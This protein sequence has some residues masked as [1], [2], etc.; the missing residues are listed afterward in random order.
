[1]T[2]G[3]GVLVAGALSDGVSFARSGA[4][5]ATTSINALAARMRMS[6]RMVAYLQK[7]LDV[8]C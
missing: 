7:K 6:V 3:R 4:L 1:L 2:V 5:H 8:G